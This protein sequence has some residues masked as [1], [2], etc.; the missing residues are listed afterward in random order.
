MNEYFINLLYALFCGL[1]WKNSHTGNY[2]MIFASIVWVTDRVVLLSFRYNKKWIWTIKDIV[3]WNLYINVL[4]VMRWCCPAFVAD[5]NFL[6]SILLIIIIIENY[7]ASNW[8]K[9]NCFLIILWYIQINIRD[10]SLW[11]VEPVLSYRFRKKKNPSFQNND[12]FF[13][14]IFEPGLKF[15]ELGYIFFN[16]LR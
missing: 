5:G 6:I 12:I 9:K 16:L 3:Y 2:V 1:I 7:Y 13:Q 10:R 14:I 11:L 4:W 8:W 15:R